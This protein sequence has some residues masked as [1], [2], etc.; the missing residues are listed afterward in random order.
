MVE[1][2]IKVVY[3]VAWCSVVFIMNRFPDSV[4]RA[5]IDRLE[6]VYLAGFIPLQLFIVM[7]S[8]RSAPASAP[9]RSTPSS[10]GICYQDA[11]PLINA[12][13]HGDCGPP[14]DDVLELGSGGM[15]FLPLMLTSVY[16]ALGLVWAFVRMSYGYVVR[17]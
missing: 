7:Y 16:C 9:A 13:H 12:M 1:S 2:I 8:T 15:E 14:P 11:N 6:K 4:L 5:V 17:E 3:S 10:P